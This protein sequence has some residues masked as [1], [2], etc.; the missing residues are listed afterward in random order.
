[1]QNLRDSTF[2]DKE[3]PEYVKDGYVMVFGK[4]YPLT[5]PMQDL[6]ATPIIGDPLNTIASSMNP[7]AKATF[8]IP[9]NKSVYTGAPID[10]EAFKNRSNEISTEAYYKYILKNMGIVGQSIYAIAPVGKDES[11]GLVDVATAL[12]TGNPYQ[13]KRQVQ[14]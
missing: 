4:P 13:D 11:K 14:K 10:T 3:Y 1:M 5:L 9:M 12:I 2:D 7:I 6:S 8:E